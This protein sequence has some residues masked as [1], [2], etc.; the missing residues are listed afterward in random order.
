MPCRV[1][2]R[3]AHPSDGSGDGSGGEPEE[4][5]VFL[6]GVYSVLICGAVY[7]YARAVLYAVVTAGAGRAFRLVYVVKP[8][9]LRTVVGSTIGVGGEGSPAPFRPSVSVARMG[10]EV[11]SSYSEQVSNA[12][13]CSGYGGS[14]GVALLGRGRR[15]FHYRGCR[16]SSDPCDDGGREG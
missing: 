3:G 6:G 9:P 1:G 11:F 10:A 2:V 4:G 5:T 12:P 14:S 13:L 15:P 16:C 8:R 7:G